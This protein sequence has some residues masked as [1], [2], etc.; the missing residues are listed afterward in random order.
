MPGKEHTFLALLNPILNGA[1]AVL[2]LC[3]RRAQLLKGVCEVLK[4]LRELVLEICELGDRKGCK[5]N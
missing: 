1:D 2:E 5:V 4:V 3:L